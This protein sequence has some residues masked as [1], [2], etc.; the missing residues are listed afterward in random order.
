MEGLVLRLRGRDGG[1]GRN[2]RADS[3][4][5][6]LKTQ[7]VGVVGGRKMNRENRRKNSPRILG[8]EAGSPKII[9]GALQEGCQR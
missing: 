1:V 8:G 3:G 5:R 4:S 7:A 9:R 6:V 2:G